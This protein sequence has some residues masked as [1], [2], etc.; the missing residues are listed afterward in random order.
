M[1]LHTENE[2]LSQNRHNAFKLKALYFSDNALFNQVIDY[3]PFPVHINKKAS[4]HISYTNDR[5]LHIGPEMDLL[6]EKG[7][8][9]LPE[10]S[11]PFLLKKAKKTYRILTNAMI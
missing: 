4:Y 8:S 1:K 2:L 11:C 6:L 10:M 5:F 3:L 7:Q 9:Y